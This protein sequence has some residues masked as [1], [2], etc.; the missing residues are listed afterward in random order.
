MSNFETLYNQAFFLAKPRQLTHNSKVGDVGAALI[1]QNGNIYSGLSLHCACGIGTCAEHAAILDM[2]KENETTILE[3]V[4]VN[5]K[6]KVLQ[7]CGR[8]RELM[9]QVSKE[10]SNTVVHL[11]NDTTKILSDLLPDYWY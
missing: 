8:C 7:P 3:V 9:M 4:A 2:L 1:T 10:N 5:D 6:G 11:A